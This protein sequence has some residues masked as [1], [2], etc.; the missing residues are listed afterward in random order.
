MKVYEVQK[1][2]TSLDGL[3]AAERPD[4]QPGWHEVLIRVRATSLNYRDQMVVTGNY[5]GGP[6]QPQ[7]DS[8][9]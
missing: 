5:F 8:A 3:R 6:V 7:P 2:A 4:P 1:G 9:L